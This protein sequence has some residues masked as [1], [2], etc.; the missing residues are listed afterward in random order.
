MR[1]SKNVDIISTKWNDC[2]CHIPANR[3]SNLTYFVSENMDISNTY[4]KWYFNS[5]SFHAFENA[6]HTKTLS[7]LL[8]LCS[9]EL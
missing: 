5:V 8:L 9:L 4:L 2:V 7:F 1:Y 3:P 6:K